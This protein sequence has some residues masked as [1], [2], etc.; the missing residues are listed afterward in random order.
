MTA[1]AFLPYGRHVVDEDDIAAVAAVLRSDWLTT[2]PTVRSFEQAL[3]RQV[4]A[5]DAISCSSGTAALH[6]A[7]AALDLDQGD[8]VVVPAITFL[9]TA[10][11]V[12]FVGGEVVFADV[13]PATGLM[14]P[15]HV[16]AALAR[17]RG[18]RARAVF[19]VHFAGQTA[20]PAGLRELADRHGLAVVE[21]ACHALGTRYH[22][23]GG[24]IPVGACRHADMAV[25]SFHPVKT[26]AMGEGGAVTAADPARA[27]RVRRLASHGMVRD[28]DGFVQADLAFAADGTANPWY[29][30]MPEIGFNYRASDIHCA[31]ALHQLGKLAAFVE[32]RRLLA[33]SYDRALQPLAPLVRPLARV[34]GS[35]PAWHLQVVRVDFAAAGVSRGALMRRLREAGIGTQV[36]YVPVPMQPYYRQRYGTQSLPGAERYYEQALTLPLFPS[37]T[38]DDVERVVAALA[39]ALAA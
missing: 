14:G 15:E 37:M 23:G 6:L 28:P 13:D 4:G 34:A 35:S 26:I 33:D 2:G 8:V 38:P 20:D 11:A 27:A 18:G 31:L 29:Y 9:A 7:A 39:D 22:D 1:T 36:H 16:E 21:D 30:E 12:R 32:Q 24:D 17:V 5:S 3:A 10:N 25:F 19:P